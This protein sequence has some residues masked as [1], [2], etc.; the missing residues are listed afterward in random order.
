MKVY[1]MIQWPRNCIAVLHVLGRTGKL[2]FI[3]CYK[4]PKYLAK[5]SGNEA[6]SSTMQFHI[7][8]YMH[9]YI[10]A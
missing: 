5:F 9:A 6:V 2:I 1:P 3:T 10:S 4:L 7:C 8:S